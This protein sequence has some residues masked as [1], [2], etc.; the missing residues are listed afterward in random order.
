MNH[1]PPQLVAIIAND[2]RRDVVDDLA[3]A[4]R[5]AAIAR[6]R[7]AHWRHGPRQAP[8]TP[9][10]PTNASVARLSWTGRGVAR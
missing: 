4:R 6:R 10:T 7:L 8:S 9:I 3:A 5:T 2:R 1:I